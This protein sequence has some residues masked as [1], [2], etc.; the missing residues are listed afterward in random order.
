MQKQGYHPTHAQPAIDRSCIRCKGGKAIG[1]FGRALCSE[2]RLE[3]MGLATVM[4]FDEW[5]AETGCPNP[6]PATDFLCGSCRAKV[7]GLFGGRGV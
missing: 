3:Q 2:C 4:V 7:A 5:C 1:A 6:H